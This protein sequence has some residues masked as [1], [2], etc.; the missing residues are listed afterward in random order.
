[1]IPTTTDT[2]FIVTIDGY[3]RWQNKARYLS[4]LTA[5]IVK[6]EA[7]Q[8]IHPALDFKANK[9]QKYMGFKSFAQTANVG[10][11]RSP[12][13]K[14]AKD[15]QQMRRFAGVRSDGRRRIAQKM[16]PLPHVINGAR[17]LAVN[18]TNSGLT[19]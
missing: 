15:K 12:T 18:M 2:F 14:S 19:T 9:R 1:M 11:Y 3:L 10:K 8:K 16:T 6:N 13:R 7:L 17:M 5:T 4:Q